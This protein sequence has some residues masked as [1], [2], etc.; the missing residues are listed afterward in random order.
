MSV[1]YAE[2]FNHKVR[3]YESILFSYACAISDGD[4]VVLTGG[5]P[6]KDEVSVYNLN[7]FQGYLPSL[8]EGRQYHACASY[9]NNYG[10][11]VKFSFRE[12]DI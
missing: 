11:K 6:H 2:E 1:E 3:K 12:A 8:N 10:E 7:G 5:F 9:T 4:R